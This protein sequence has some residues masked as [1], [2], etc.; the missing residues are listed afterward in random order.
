LDFANNKEFSHAIVI[1]QDEMESA[2]L[3]MKNLSS[4]DQTKQ[5]VE[6]CISILKS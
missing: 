6:D 2:V 4:G 1:G 5:G 3:T